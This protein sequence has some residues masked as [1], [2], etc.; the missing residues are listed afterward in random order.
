MKQEVV[1]YI[2]G[3]FFLLCLSV[4]ILYC[5]SSV[6]VIVRQ[7]MLFMDNNPPFFTDRNA[8]KGL[9]PLY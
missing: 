6:L 7:Y 5:Y 3:G 2:A 8:L 4:S 1:H 9:I